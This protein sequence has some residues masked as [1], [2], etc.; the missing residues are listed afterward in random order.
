LQALRRFYR[1]A[2]SEAIIHRMLDDPAAGRSGLRHLRKENV[3]GSKIHRPISREIDLSQATK[4]KA[5]KATTEPA[6]ESRDETIARLMAV[7]SDLQKQI[8]DTEAEYKAELRKLN[9]Q[10]V[11]CEAT[12]RKLIRPVGYTELRAKPVD[13]TIT[14]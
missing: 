14:A 2:N 10:F 9:T 12:L 5:L 13:G 11:E 6:D 8:V 1:D 7:R 3:L 4:E